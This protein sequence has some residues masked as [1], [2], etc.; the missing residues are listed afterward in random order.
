M[1]RHPSS[2]TPGLS[3]PSFARGV[4]FRLLREMRHGK[5]ELRLPE[6]DT[7]TFGKPTA[8]GS[9]HDARENAGRLPAPDAEIRIRNEAFFKKCL[10]YGDIGFGE[11]YVDGDW[12]TPSIQKVIR[13]FIANTEH[14][15]A[16][17][18]TGGRF[19]PVNLLTWANRI[20]HRLRRN[21]LRMSRRNIREHYDLSRQFFASFLDSG[22]TYSS[23]LWN[24]G[25]ATLEE[26]QEAKYERFCR[27]LRL[28][29]EHSILEIGCGWGGFM[30]YAARNYGC[31][32]TGLTLSRDQADFTATRLEQAGLDD[33][34]RVEM[35]DY[36]EVRGGFDRIVSI[37]M[38]E[39]VGYRYLPVFLRRC[40]AL[41]N[42]RGLLG[43]QFI[44]YPDSR[45]ASLRREVD[46]IQKHIFPGS[47]LLSVNRIN[48]LLQK[49]GLQLHEMRDMAPDYARTLREWQTRFQGELSR[50]RD[51]GFDG[52]FIR[53]WS[54]YLSYCEAAFASRNISV[55]QT[56]H[57][58]ANNPELDRRAE[59]LEPGP[60]RARSI[61][62]A[63]ERVGQL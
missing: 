36:R 50:I 41:L 54:Y 60:A 11:S 63:G 40:A 44:T 32:V 30:E 16:A 1:N 33:R 51:L 35:I 4:L 47:L 15:R 42:P 19:A 29:P 49:S 59:P 39:A 3:G 12:D 13:W 31:R 62:P 55:V 61:I 38:I 20:R 6:G 25:A 22:M 18:G 24:Q 28:R 58:P 52:G 56:I 21:S 17:P 5:L 8:T 27:S 10:L 37:E 43:M 14:T 26:A 2:K 9:L 7:V 34:A 46:W 48:A 45:Y 23:G 57:S 53:K